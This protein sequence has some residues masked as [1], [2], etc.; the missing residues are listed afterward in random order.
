LKELRAALRHGEA[1]VVR[2]VNP[3]VISV[4]A[5]TVAT[6]HSTVVA[7]SSAKMTPAWQHVEH[8]GILAR[9]AAR[10]SAAVMGIAAAVFVTGEIITTPALAM[11]ALLPSVVILAKSGECSAMLQALRGDARRVEQLR[12]KVISRR[13]WITTVTRASQLIKRSLLSPCALYETPTF[14]KTARVMRRINTA[15][16]QTARL[17]DALLRARNVEDVISNTRSRRAP[18]LRQV[19]ASGW[20]NGVF[21]WRRVLFAAA[22]AAFCNTVLLSFAM[23]PLAVVVA[24]LICSGLLGVRYFLSNWEMRR[25]EFTV[26][27][28]SMR[29]RYPDLL[30]DI[31]QTIQDEIDR[32]VSLY[33]NGL[34]VEVDTTEDLEPQL[35]RQIDVAITYG[36][37]SEQELHDVLDLRALR[38]NYRPSSN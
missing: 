27:R 4:L 36:A 31:D 30:R 8:R 6:L 28:M 7:P 34:D 14:G 37:Q 38:D 18:D 2:Q 13:H 24:G 5:A 16:L 12:A 20:T 3:A 10:L 22:L 17:D 32:L 11:L 15:A 25:V 33:A 29:L 23:H 21:F 19:V 35:R 26:R 9:D 1:V